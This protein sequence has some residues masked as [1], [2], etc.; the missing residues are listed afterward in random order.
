MGHGLPSALW[1]AVLDEIAALT[2]QKER[3]AHVRPAAAD[4]SHSDTPGR[5]SG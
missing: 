5:G 3:Q 2:G 4:S 1:T